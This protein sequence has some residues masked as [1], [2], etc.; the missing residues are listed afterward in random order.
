[1]DGS[2]VLEWNTA[3]DSYVALH[4]ITGVV[5][6]APA[7]DMIFVGSNTDSRATMIKPGGEPMLSFSVQGLRCF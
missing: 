6:G 1:M 4:N 5:T 3:N 2:G 7:D